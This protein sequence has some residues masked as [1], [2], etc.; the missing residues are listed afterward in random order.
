MSTS[1]PTDKQGRYLLLLGG[2]NAGLSARKRE[3]DP[4]LKRGWVTAEWHAPYYQWVRI[5]PDGLRALAEHV[6]KRGLPDAKPNAQVETRQCADCG[7]TRW[8]YAKRDVAADGTVAKEDEARSS[9]SVRTDSD[10]T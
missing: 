4:L 10:D 5:T 1:A 7:S 9:L 6:E 3:V 2:G 8:R